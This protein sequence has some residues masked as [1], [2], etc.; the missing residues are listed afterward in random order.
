LCHFSLSGISFI[1]HEKLMNL[2]TAP[3]KYILGSG[4]VCDLNYLRDFPN[5]NL[6]SY[7]ECAFLLSLFI[8]LQIFFTL[9]YFQLIVLLFRV[10][11]TGNADVVI[12][13]YFAY[14]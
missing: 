3:T 7:E 14:S 10:L 11:N 2:I 4:L 8:T 5:I 13:E 12:A 1:F 9:N 6:I